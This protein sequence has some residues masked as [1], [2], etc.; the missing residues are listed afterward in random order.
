MAA[1][2]QIAE[3]LK[4]LGMSEYAERFAE[5]RIDLSVLRDLTDQDLKDLG[6]VLGDRRKM[7]RAIAELGG[8]APHRAA[9]TVP[10]AP[11]ETAERRQLTVMFCD[12]V[13]S[14]A[15][16]GRLDPE[17][18]REV[19]RAYQDACSGP[20]ARYDGFIAKFM[21]DGILAYFGFPRA[22]EDDAERAVRAALDI[23]AAVGRLRPEPLKVRVGVATGLVVV[24]D[25]IGEGTSQ[26]QAVVG[27]TPNLAAR[28]QAL[29][30]PGTI[31]V[32]GS[33]RR[34]LGDV[35]KL[36]DLGRHEAKGFVEPVN[37]WAVEALTA[38]ESR[39]EAAHAAQ[40]TGFV[41]RE[42]EIAL[43]IDRKNL[44][45][46]GEGQIVLIS[47]EPG[48]GKSR[49]AA[50]LSARSASEPHTR[51]RHQCSPYH[52]DSALYP[53]IARLER[54]AELKPD[55]QPELR[56]DR[57]EA[58][59]ARAT[60]R[61]QSVAPLF[62]ALLSIPFAGRYPPLALS[63]AQQRRQT[64]AALLDQF[65][66]LARQQP[67]LLLFED[68]QWA[69][70]TSIELL[71]LT[72]ERIRYLP[73]LAIFT[74]RPEFEPPWAGLPNVTT[75][76]L[77]RLDHSHA[78]TLAEQ[79]AGSRRLPKEVMGQI[80]AKTDGIPLFVEEL[81]KA[82]LEA[83][84]L[85]EDAEGYRLDGP[86]PPLAIP[87][88]LHDSLMARLDRLAPVK[89]IAQVGAAIGREFSYALLHVVTGRDEA[90][91]DSA[92][93]Q[94]EQAE[95]VFRTRA[96]PD[97]RYTFKHALVQ[98][99]AYESLLKSRRQVLHRRIAG[100][101]RDRFPSLADTEPE[102]VAHHFTESGLTEA[103]VEWWAKAGDRAMQGSAYNE[104]IAHLEKAN[105]L[106]EGLPDGPA[107]KLLGLRV[108]TT[109]SN[110]LFHG[111]GFTAAET[112][113]AFMR[114]RALAAGVPDPTER[115]SA[116]FGLWGGS[117][118]RAELTPMREVAEAFLRDTQSRPRSSEAAIGR[119]V[120]GTTCWFQGDY[121]GARQQLEQAL[122]DYDHERDRHLAARFGFDPG[123]QAMFPL[124]M[125]LWPLGDVDRPAHLLEEGLKLSLQS[126]HIPTVA[127]AH[128]YACHF[129]AIRR[130]PDQ[131]KI[132]AEALFG[133]APDRGL[134]HFR[135]RGTFLH[136]WARSRAGDPDGEAG[137][138]EGLALL[139]EAGEKLFE[140][141]FATLLAEVEAD[142][143]RADVGLATLEAQLVALELSGQ[144]WFEAEMHRVRGD[145]LLKRCP[146][147]TTAEVAFRRAI[148]IARIQQ[149]RTF[150]LRAAL[151]LTRLYQATSRHEAAREVLAPALV[152]FREGPELPEVGESK[153]LLASLDQ[154]PGAAV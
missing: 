73:V 86:L 111:R 30:D 12:L 95:L 50:A 56:L 151:A 119:R 99:A 104:A 145:L 38:S 40:L 68:V 90:S 149:T 135:A 150:E 133:L 101:L 124:A 65:E 48:I 100:A 82:V 58:V 125:V 80:I 147:T 59:L 28:L 63:P 64:L 15:L 116:Y 152:G 109:Y 16:S 88:T 57:L 106:A 78:Q 70:A 81:T 154:T 3:W 7:L 117:L 19:I 43:L 146:D 27:D 42:R 91:L 115:F 61:V 98:D 24:G 20:V 1:M 92:L 66:G 127:F 33:T 72:V 84:I 10:P 112:T 62:A 121:V 34:L 44:A 2:Q 25:L 53:F 9:T 120:L 77:G 52:K 85:V 132:H 144:R 45:W 137:M 74:F 32:A 148:E 126:G 21:G 136:G 97:L 83:G 134:P 76:A 13:G 107:Q 17:E 6:V 39:F 105:D 131:A 51:L 142:S 29:A 75:L 60:S 114:V 4:K 102:I 5:N 138:R 122:A 110:A 71:D 143:G 93:S 140:P 69:D 54:V 26:E 31:V 18:M 55:D 130:R 153:R 139:A 89:E 11:E 141:L 123:V 94:L 67:I 22:H 118:V 35:F 14:T 8:A 108:Q 36:R 87:A 96:P 79:V 129:G 128:M 47:G 103:A 37:A 49:I 23:V 46:Q 41:G 113:A